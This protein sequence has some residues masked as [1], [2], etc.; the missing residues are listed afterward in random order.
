M[1][2]D[3][4]VRIQAVLFAVLYAIWILPDTILIRNTCLILGALISIYEIAAFRSQLK[5]YKVIPLLLIAGLFFWMTFHL[6][7]LSN[8]F[9]LQLQEYLSIWKRS[10]FGA[11]F[12]L[13]LALAIANSSEK[14]K[15]YAWIIF[16]FGLLLPTLIYIFKYF[17]V[18]YGQAQHVEIPSYWRIYPVGINAKYYIAK[19]AYV[20]FCA[21]V[22]CI[23]LGCLYRNFQRGI[24]LDWGNLIYVLTIP[25]VLFVFYA[26]NIKNGLVFS[27]LFLLIFI[28]SV[29]I[30]F[31][32]VAPKK[33]MALIAILIISISFISFK[34][35]HENQ[36]WRTLSSDARVALETERYENWKCGRD[37]GYPKNESGEVVSIT[38]Y[39]RIAWGLSAL[40][41]IIEYPLGYGLV[42]RSFGQYGQMLWPD[43]CLSQ[44]HSGWLDLTLGIGIPGMLIIFSAILGV[45]I[46]IFKIKAPIQSEINCWITMSICSFFSF[47]MIWITTEISQKVFF[48]E[49]IFFLVLGAGICTYKSDSI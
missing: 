23:A 32:R 13:G 36:S 6:F 30:T 24:W 11:I 4:L 7:F 15:R 39:D 47:S 19:T 12:A 28:V 14:I 45:L 46:I 8:D 42:E 31:F 49:L 22:I 5:S 25:A 17:L 18:M 43:S 26:E 40:K 29:G 35:I 34:H 21:P 48:D 3:L 27:L 9:V 37:K 38:N 44:S 16:Y 2:T 1:K 20:G 33:S 10:L 41:L